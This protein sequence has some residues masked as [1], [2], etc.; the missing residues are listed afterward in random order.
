[1][2]R[3]GH[4]RWL[5]ALAV[6]CSF[7]TLVA[8]YGGWLAPSRYGTLPALM[9]LAYPIIACLQLV[10]SVLLLLLGHRRAALAA[11]LSL[12]ATWPSLR[13][14]FPVNLRTCASDEGNHFSVMS[15]NVASFDIN[16]WT[17]TTVMHP[18]M[19]VVLKQNADMVIL[20]Q[21]T[22]YGKGYDE[23]KFIE[24]WL[25]EI[26]RC[27]PYRSHSRYDGVELLSKYPFKAQ[28]LSL[29]VHSYLY[30]PYVT[31][32]TNSYAFD[33]QLPEGRQ[34]R[35]VAAYMTSFLLEDDERRVLDSVGYVSPGRL[36][37]K[38]SRA[39]ADRELQSKKL[40]DSLDLSPANVIV[41]TD[42]NDVPQSF[43]YR[44]LMG[45][46]MSDAY[47]QCHTGYVNT[48]NGHN[49]LFHIDHILYR[50]TMRACNFE[51][52]KVPYSD[53][54]PIVATFKWQ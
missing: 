2:P 37:A 3:H 38:L 31:R 14:N 45:H 44:T 42:L 41:C 36:Y 23:R 51:R 19:R 13:A 39:F 21:P 10:V 40:R 17:D 28:P 18:A 50:G 15:Y 20:L 25:E 6:V 47:G 30:Y 8:G 52:L 35:L 54:Y 53:H 4:N 34:L 43:A 1:M 29:P 46:D 12:L 9:V 32:A 5:A 48:F 26:D 49:M 16:A 33:I 24:P 11:G 27:Y 7:V 22:N